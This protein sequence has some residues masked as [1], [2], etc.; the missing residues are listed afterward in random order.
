MN[1]P[2]EIVQASIFSQYFLFPPFQALCLSN[3]VKQGEGMSHAGTE[4]GSQE[5][6]PVLQA[7][8][9]DPGQCTSCASVCV[10]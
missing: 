1:N 8:V 10:K 3:A 5:L 4:S 9:G 6:R 7:R 2:T